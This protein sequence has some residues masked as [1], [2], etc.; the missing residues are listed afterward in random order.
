M[1]TQPLLLL[2]V[3][4]GGV[5]G[6]IAIGLRV[7]DTTQDTST[8]TAADDNSRTIEYYRNPMDASITSPVP[9]KDTMGMDYIPVYAET[10]TT[11]EPVILYYRNP[12]DASITSP[13]PAKDYMGM[14][15]I[16]VYAD[17]AGDADVDADAIRIDPQVVQNLGV[18]TAIVERMPFARVFNTV[19][20]VV[21]DERGRAAFSPK[22]SGWLERLHVKAVG[23][24]VEKGAVLAEIYAPELLAAQEEYRVALEAR[25]RLGTVRDPGVHHDTDALVEAARERLKLLDLSAKEISALER[26]AHP[27]RTVMLHAPFR[28]TVMALDV[29]EGVSVTPQMRL[30]TLTDLSRVWVNVDIYADQLPWVRINDPVDL[31]LAHL[32]GREWHGHVDYLYPTMNTDSRTVIARLVFD[33]HDG[34]LRPGMYASARFEADFREDVLAVANEAVI[35]TGTHDAVMLALGDGRFKPAAVKLG[36]ENNGYV[37]ITD[38]LQAGQRIVLSGQFLLDAEASFRG[39][40][41]RMQGGDADQSQEPGHVH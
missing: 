22:V 21:E 9:A 27:Q 32:P 3:L 5:A 16:P 17:D 39:A 35:R 11:T 6:G 28:G 30:L 37:E 41:L 36:A 20:T 8:M 34:V 2:L 14:D 10:E 7:A 12:M 4:I 29:R 1:K 33:N 38:G 19:G 24:V 31:T 40:G 23:D 15:Y 25:K 26:G 18:R 13:L